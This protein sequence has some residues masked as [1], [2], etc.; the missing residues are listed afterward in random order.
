[1]EAK[2]PIKQTPAKGNLTVREAGRLGGEKVLLL[3]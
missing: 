3:A 1:M 2:R